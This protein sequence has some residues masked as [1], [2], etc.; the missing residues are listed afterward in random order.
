LAANI[1]MAFRRRTSSEK[2]KGALA[3]ILYSMIG[4]KPGYFY[5]SIEPLAKANGNK[6]KTLDDAVSQIRILTI[7]ATFVMLPPTDVLH[8]FSVRFGAE[9]L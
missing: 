1:A 2:R 4:P 5:W 8:P 9:D 3:Q 7:C 6:N